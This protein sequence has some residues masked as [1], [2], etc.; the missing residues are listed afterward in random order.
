MLNP[1]GFWAQ[2]GTV[3]GQVNAVGTREALSTTQCSSKDSTSE[4]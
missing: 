1:F 3:T 4:A 2:T